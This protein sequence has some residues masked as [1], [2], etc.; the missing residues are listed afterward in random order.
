MLLRVGLLSRLA[1]V[2]ALHHTTAIVIRV[3]TVGAVDALDTV[4]CPDA[5]RDRAG[6][7]T[8]RA[9]EAAHAVRTEL[10]RR[11]DHAVVVVCI[12]RSASIARLARLACS[13]G[14]AVGRLV[15][16]VRIIAVQALRAIRRR[17]LSHGA[18][19]TDAVAACCS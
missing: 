11:T 12:R 5:K 8:W 15:E 6:L 14:P 9:E 19:L 4:G 10:A 18:P 2:A 3:V 17:L 1:R 16:L 7:L 13:T